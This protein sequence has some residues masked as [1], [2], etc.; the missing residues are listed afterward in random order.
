MNETRIFWTEKEWFELL[1]VAKIEPTDN[2][3]ERTRKLARAQKKALSAKRR[4][5]ERSLKS[6]AFATAMRYVALM[7]EGWRP[8]GVEVAPPE[9]ASV[10]IAPP[11]RSTKKRLE[12]EALE[13]TF[14]EGA[15]YW[16]KR[17]RTIVA[18]AVKHKIDSGDARRLSQI[19]FEAQVEFLPRERCRT[20]KSFHDAVHLR[21]SHDEGLANA[22]TLPPE[23]IAR[24]TGR[25]EEYEAQRARSLNGAAYQVEAAPAEA[26][27]PD[28]TPTTSAPASDPLAASLM[29][30]L[31]DTAARVAAATRQHIMTEL[32]ARMNTIVASLAATLREQVHAIL[33]AELG[34]LQTTPEA[35]ATARPPAVP[36]PLPIPAAHRVRVDIVGL[37]GNGLGAV[38]EAT[39]RLGVAARFIE[40]DKVKSW[41]PGENVIMMR[42]FVPHDVD[43]R[44]AKAGSNLMIANA[45]PQS[46][47]ALIESLVASSNGAPQAR[48]Q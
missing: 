38:R 4:R 47:I 48:L 40:S 19:Y 27:S 5:S 32:D 21:K 8:E 41:Q 37:V 35:P 15:I 3:A 24:L 23:E 31:G 14:S 9:V 18:V 39:A 33:A 26:P 13:A 36:G 46:V 34:G 10:P 45:G 16:T 29:T 44:A 1:T 12:R 25:A 2:G 43:N 11:N 7:A 6:T 42:K 28:P 22:W 17:E 20:S 30:I